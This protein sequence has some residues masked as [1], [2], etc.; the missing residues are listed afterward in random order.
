MDKLIKPL[1]VTY[2]LKCEYCGNI[3]TFIL[4]DIR[5]PKFCINP[6]T[7]EEVNEVMHKQV[8]NPYKREFCDYCDA[9]T[10]QKIVRW[11]FET[12]E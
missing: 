7:E 4:T 11:D 2:S 1:Y 9:D 10:L 8:C 3:A 6:L 5:S 12:K